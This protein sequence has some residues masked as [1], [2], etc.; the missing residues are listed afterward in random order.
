MTLSYPLTW[1]EINTKAILHNIK[2]IKKLLPRQTK[3][4]AVIKA[5]AYG[6]GLLKVGKAVEKHCDY[7]AVFDFKDAITLRQNGIK[8]PLMVLGTAPEECLSDALKFDI[9]ITISSFTALQKLIKFSQ[10]KKSAKKIQVHICADTGMGRDGFLF[11]D[12]KLL[13]SKLKNQK[14]FII[15]GF[16]THFSAV[17]E[18]ALEQHTQKQISEFA[19]WKKALAEVEIKPIFHQSASAATIRGI[20]TDIAR[21]GIALYGLW[22]SLEIR[23]NLKNK[24]ELKPALSWKARII[25]IRNLPKNSPIS[26]GLTHK[27]KRDSKLAVLPIGYYDGVPRITSSKGHF[28]VKGKKVPQIGRITMNMV[29]LDVTDLSGVKVGDIVTIIGVD[30]K[31]HIT[32]EDWGNWAQTIAYEITTRLNADMV[33][34]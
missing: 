21:V 22:P 9:E 20:E 4:M 33:R 28:L 16:Y 27:L 13:L 14:N 30:G 2:E 10:Q 3:F 1:L 18:A 34:L 32:A 11:K 8:L 19:S 31:N 26:Y 17:D 12:A 6:H 15:K 5:N 23:D 24:L 25:D 29:V 7:L